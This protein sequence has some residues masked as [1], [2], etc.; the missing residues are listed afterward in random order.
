MLFFLCCLFFSVSSFHTFLCPGKKPPQNSSCLFFWLLLDSKHSLSRI[1]QEVTQ[2]L[3]LTQ[4]RSETFNMAFT[5]THKPSSFDS[6]LLTVPSTTLWCLLLIIR[7]FSCCL[8]YVFA[9]I[10]L[11]VLVDVFIQWFLRVTSYETKSGLN[12][13]PQHFPPLIIVLLAWLKKGPYPPPVYK[14]RKRNFPLYDVAFSVLLFNYSVLLSF[15]FTHSYEITLRS[16]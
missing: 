9:L 5:H 15:T 4:R 3:H 7:L 13:A 8:F 12:V 14:K 1:L 10:S 16:V 6:H 2:L 11:D